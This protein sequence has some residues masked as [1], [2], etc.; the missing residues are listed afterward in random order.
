[1]IM[2]IE[3]IKEELETQK[4]INKDCEAEYRRVISQYKAVVEQNKQLQ[5]ELNEIK[6]ES[7]K[8]KQQYNC[9]A[10]DTCKGKE[11]YR[12]LARHFKSLLEAYHKK[13]KEFYKYKNC[14]DDIKDELET[15]S[16][17]E[18]EECGCD[19]DSECLKCTIKLILKKINEVE[20]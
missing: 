3:E 15:S 7:E 8:I 18:S 4:Q 20:K 6:K 1:M 2:K 5:A 11:D 9:Y 19:D 12:N 13:I 16:H 17:C 14:L 10:C